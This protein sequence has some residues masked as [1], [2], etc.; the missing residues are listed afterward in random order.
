MASRDESG[1][2]GTLSALSPGGEE[3]FGRIPIW[4]NALGGLVLA[5]MLCLL[6]FL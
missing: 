5:V 1:R 6:L 2:T 3:L 4:V